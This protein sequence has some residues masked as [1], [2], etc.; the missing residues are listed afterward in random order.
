M[1]DVFIAALFAV[2]VALTVLAVTAWYHRKGG[3]LDQAYGDGWSDAV[4]ENQVRDRAGREAGAVIDA[5][6]WA[7]Q[8][9]NRPDR[10]PDLSMLEMQGMASDESG[11]PV[12]L[13][14]DE[15]DQLT[16]ASPDEAAETLISEWHAPDDTGHDGLGELMQL[17]EIRWC[18]R[19][20]LKQ[21]NWLQEM[22]READALCLELGITA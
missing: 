12:S 9:E 22:H 14:P 6:E 21:W 7:A 2:A 19:E 13:S 10:T 15:F 17:I 1:S 5:E 20:H 4:L 16:A 8:P 3:P 11:I 18:D